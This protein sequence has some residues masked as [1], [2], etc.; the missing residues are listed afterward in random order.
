MRGRLSDMNAV[1]ARIA[2]LGALDGKRLADEPR[3]ERIVVP[4]SGVGVCPFE[5]LKRF[6]HDYL[7]AKN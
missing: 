7:F 1:A 3:A 6:A 5:T 4:R 2:L